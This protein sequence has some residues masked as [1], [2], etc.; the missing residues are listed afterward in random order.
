MT[1]TI[2]NSGQV[3][4]S[5]KTQGTL[6]FSTRPPPG[7]LPVLLVYAST[8][9]PP[10]LTLFIIEIRKKKLSLNRLY[11][12]SSTNTIKNHLFYPQTFATLTFKISIQSGIIGLTIYT[13]HS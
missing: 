2:S 5:S 3:F 10:Q 4:G 7:L 12:I 13:A 9:K 8:S 11:G 6:F 1:N